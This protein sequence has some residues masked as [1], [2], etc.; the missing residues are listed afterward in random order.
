MFLVGGEVNRQCESVLAR[1]DKGMAERRHMIQLMGCVSVIP[2]ACNRTYC[3]LESYTPEDATKYWSY[4]E[5]S[6]G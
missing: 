2:Q 6:N 1:T 3:T 5:D 4:P